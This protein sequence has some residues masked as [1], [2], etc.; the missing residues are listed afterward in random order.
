L[1]P[2]IV[3]WTWKRFYKCVSYSTWRSKGKNSR[4]PK[5]RLAK[6]N[7]IYGDSNY[8]QCDSFSTISL[9]EILAWITI[10]PMTLE[11][12][13]F[14]PS[15]NAHF[16]NL[17]LQSCSQSCSS[18]PISRS[19]TETSPVKK[20][21]RFVVLPSCLS[22]KVH[23]LINSSFFSTKDVYSAGDVETFVKPWKLTQDVY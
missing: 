2:E 5:W 6:R 20:Q 19:R 15:P 9:I 7:H 8:T 22:K 1:D 11:T 23:S 17:V 13:R 14:W 4:L 3:S 16:K 21:H 12:P 10:V 18:S